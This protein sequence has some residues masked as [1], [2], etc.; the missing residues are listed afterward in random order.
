[1]MIKYRVHEV[2]KDFGV[3]SEDIIAILSEYC[4]G[5]KKRMTVLEENEL[6]IIFEKLTRNCYNY[7]Y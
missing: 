1:M 6:D 3:S 2:A 7:K 5:E 4:E